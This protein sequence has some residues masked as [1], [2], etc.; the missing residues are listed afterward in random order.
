MIE[1]SK[2]TQIERDRERQRERQRETERERQTER[3]G[4]KYVDKYEMDG[5]NVLFCKIEER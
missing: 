3:K 4:N 5:L 1:S 2:R